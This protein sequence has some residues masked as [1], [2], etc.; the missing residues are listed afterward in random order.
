MGDNKTDEPRRTS[1][2]EIKFEIVF[3]ASTLGKEL[4]G[5]NISIHAIP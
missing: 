1:D 3:G 2:P 4:E 5:R